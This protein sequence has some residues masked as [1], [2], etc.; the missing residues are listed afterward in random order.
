MFGIGVP[1]MIKMDDEALE[2]EVA[3]ARQRIVEATAEGSSEQI[4]AR[5]NGLAKTEAAVR[6]YATVRRIVKNGS[7][8]NQTQAEVNQSLLLAAGSEMAQGADDEWSGRGN[9]LRRAADEGKRKAWDAVLT[10]IQFGWEF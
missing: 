8:K 6:V 10:S 9:D 5:V 3:H 7:L 2:K 4:L 1:E